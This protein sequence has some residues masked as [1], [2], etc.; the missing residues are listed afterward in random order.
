MRCHESLLSI[1]ASHR[2]GACA[3]LACAFFGTISSRFSGVLAREN[4]CGGPAG[5]ASGAV[6]SHLVSLWCHN[7]VFAVIGEVV[8]PHTITS[9]QGSE[10]GG[11]AGLLNV[12]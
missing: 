7:L 12:W 8:A 3:I 10:T 6:E 5:W 11:K 1:D 2:K 4:F 9:N